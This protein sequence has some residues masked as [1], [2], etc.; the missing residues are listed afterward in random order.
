MEDLSSQLR[1]VG[2]LKRHR[3]GGEPSDRR[4]A[5]TAGV[6]HGTPG[7]W[8]DGRQLPQRIDTL[9][10]VLGGIRAEAA[11]RG[12]LAT[13]VDA[14]GED[15]VAE[16]LDERRW[17][18]AF[19]TERAHR[20]ERSR[21]D[22]EGRQAQAASER[23][24]LRARQAALT[25]RPRPVR[26]W[27]AGRLGVHPA[28]PGRGHAGA[29]GAA[30]VLPRYVPR[31]HDVRLHRLLAAAVTDG[32]DPVLVVVQGSSCTGKSRTAYEALQEAVPDSFDLAFPGDADS[33]LA[34]LAADALPP[35]S[36][37]WLNEAQHHLAGPQGEAV[38]AALQ[39]RLDGDGPLL[40]IATLWPEYAEALTRPAPHF[41]DVHRHARA[42][43]AQ[44]QWVDL[45]RTFAE[46][47][48][49][50]RAGAAWDPSLAEAVA[51]GSCELTQVLA[52]APDLV[53]HFEQPAG[54][55]GPYGNALISAA[56][57]AHR[58]GVLGPLP[59]AFLEAAAAGYLTDGERAAAGPDWCGHAL[60]RARTLIKHTTSPLQD[61]PHPT[62]MGKLPG[63]ARLADYLQHY[64]RRARRFLCPPDSFWNAAR[65]HLTAPEGLL[66][67]GDAAQKR[68]RY[69]HAAQLYGA[70]ADA[71]E[72]YALIRLGHM[73][74]EALDIEEAERLYRLAAGAGNTD[75][76]LHLA[77]MWEDAWMWEETEQLYL[78]V[79]AA[80]D[81]DALAYAGLMWE[82]AGEP[83]RA[84]A[85][86]ER[87]LRS[88]DTDVLIPMARMRWNEGRVQ[89]AADLYRQ[90]YDAG[91]ADALN[92]LVCLWEETGQQEEADR[93]LRLFADAGNTGALLGVAFMLG[94]A[95]NRERAEQL[96]AQAASAG[97]DRAW[98]LL[99]AMW[100]R[101][102]D[103]KKAES[104][105]R[106]AA[107]AGDVTAL[108]LLAG[109]REAAL[110]P[111]EAERLYWQ[112]ANAGDEKA[113]ACM[114]RL[115]EAA[116]N[117]ER[118]EQLYRMA[119]D[120]GAE[121]AVM[122]L[123]R[124]RNGSE[125]AYMQYGLTSDGTVSEPWEWPLVP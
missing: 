83:D 64:G 120:T 105:F 36:V 57:D 8:L 7:A 91:N 50:A 30:F 67:L 123:A 18:A 33:L 95:G 124:L 125:E 110:D 65:E 31:R 118:A 4:L 21:R 45:P 70:A 85:A 86:Y 113:L 89:E 87:A 78:Q 6:S 28:I 79:A 2:A 76:L 84:W 35:R 13:R 117:R 39:R 96:Y 25:D 73:R 20:S 16:L 24:A 42:L 121:A 116:G 27:S 109:L 12:L 60:A 53:R 94:R 17:R 100:K 71:G 9:L 114:A 54:P 26:S 5:R 44:A 52:A 19:E 66:R 68:A 41:E 22:A 107:A 48:D 61:V 93:Q 102:G 115:Q 101:A 56:M 55:H 92:Q 63:T 34:V 10:A 37:L 38:A 40:V 99:A 77:S 14:S 47:L 90:A 106:R 112:A 62:G 74:E 15:T 98:F 97:D 49:A 122:S 108:R 32:A 43:L 88:G 81:P 103:L 46:D 51:A 75:A 119:A 3:L 58:L 29:H 104:C 111:T 72:P 23:D 82:S 11:R 59:L 80:G 1:R 69:F